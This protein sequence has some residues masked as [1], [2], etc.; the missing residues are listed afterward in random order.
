MDVHNL[1][2]AGLLI[3]ATSHSAVVWLGPTYAA[4][5]EAEAGTVTEAEPSTEKSNE[6]G[7]ALSS[8]PARL[9]AHDEARHPACGGRRDPQEHRSARR[10]GSSERNHNAER[11]RRDQRRL[12]TP[13]MTT[14]CLVTLLHPLQSETPRHAPVNDIDLAVLSS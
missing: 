3:L 1:M 13:V 8:F 12:N 9:R 5:M 4:E 11:R 14:A 6:D 2:A 10:P 7:P